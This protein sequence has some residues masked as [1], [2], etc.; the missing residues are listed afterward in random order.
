MRSQ[1]KRFDGF[2]GDFRSSVGD[3]NPAVLSELDSSAIGPTCVHKSPRAVC[4]WL[5]ESSKNAPCRSFKYAKTDATKVEET[6]IPTRMPR[7]NCHR[8]I[9]RCRS[10]GTSPVILGDFRMPNKDLSESSVQ[11]SKGGK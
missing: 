5:E 9:E 3:K 2:D 11:S 1:T 4:V 8:T 7:T 6:S 10:K